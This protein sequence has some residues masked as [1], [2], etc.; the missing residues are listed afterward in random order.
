[1]KSTRRVSSTNP[2]I[3]SLNDFFNKPDNL[4]AMLS[5]I[6]TSKN[7]SLRIIDWFVTNYSKK[8]NTSYI[9][10]GNTKK[11]LHSNTTFDPLFCKEFNVYIDY[12]LQLKAYSKKLF[13]PFCR[14]RRID[15][16]YNKEG[17]QTYINKHNLTHTMADDFFTTTVGQLNFFRWII[18]NDILS[19]IQQ[20]LN[21]IEL[22]M[23]DCYKK[24]YPIGNK[25]SQKSR[26]K[27]QEISISATKSLSKSNVRVLITFD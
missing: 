9:T 10:N 14:R 19:Y 1:M 12:K 27:R 22:D 16:Y 13:D 21:T 3:E 15:F 18:N 26:K 23:N 11:L 24:Q 25:A 4:Y 8:N 2:L 6:T 5:V 7:I 17:L 20:N